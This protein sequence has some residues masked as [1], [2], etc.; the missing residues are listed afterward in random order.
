MR[1][2]APELRRGPPFTYIKH[3][4]GGGSFRPA[5]ADWVGLAVVRRP[6][7]VVVIVVVVVIAGVVPVAVIAVV[8]VTPGTVVA[9]AVAVVAAEGVNQVVDPVH[10]VVHI[11][12]GRDPAQRPG[13]GVEGLPQ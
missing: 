7:A 5:C 3:Q 8:I 9:R 2:A 6:V 11:G 1:R 4:P 10:A 12:P 13:G